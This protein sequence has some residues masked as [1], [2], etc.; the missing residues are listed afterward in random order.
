MATSDELKIWL[1]VA[2]SLFPKAG[3]AVVVFSLVYLARQTWRTREDWR[4]GPPWSAYTRYLKKLH[5][6]FSYT[7]KQGYCNQIAL[8][9]LAHRPD[10]GKRFNSDEAYDL[11]SMLNLAVLENKALLLTGAK[12]VG[13]TALL[14]RLALRAGSPESHRKLGFAKIRIPFYI[15]IK[16]VN[17]DLPFVRAL[18]QALQASALPLS[19]CA[20]KGALRK[21]RALFLFDGLDELEGNRARQTFLRW[22]EEAQKREARNA[23][24]VLACRPEALLFGVDVRVPHFTVGLRNFALQKILALRAVTETRMPPVLRNSCEAGAEYILIS[25]PSPPATLRGANKTPPHYHYHLAKYPVTNRLYRAFV[26]AGNYKAPRF[27]EEKEFAGEDLP[28]V[29]VDWEEAESYCAW[30]NHISKSSVQNDFI[31]RLPSEE[32]WEWAASANVRRYPWGDSAPEAKHA[33]FGEHGSSLTPVH[34]HLAGATPEGLCGMAGNV[35]EWTSTTMSVK[36]EKRIVRGGAAF[37]DASV[38]QCVSRDSHAKE[39][40]RFVGFRIA[41]VPLITAW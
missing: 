28:V 3:F 7:Q 6:Q 10:T 14:H 16:H 13:K 34:A 17:T 30:L 2:R 38:L 23:Q 39:R 25:P 11:E 24:F 36:P 26:Q 40:S 5:T 32:E 21:R 15:P 31:F 35:W 33:N 12:N 18:A 4:L 29:G 27:W 37:N 9:I 8:Y 22:L 19:A 20:I 1:E 41:R